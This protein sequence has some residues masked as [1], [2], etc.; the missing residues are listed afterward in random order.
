M[1]MQSLDALRKRALKASEAGDLPQAETLLR[2]AEYGFRRLTCELIMRRGDLLRKT[3]RV[4]EAIQTFAEAA[5]LLPNEATPHL[6]IAETERARRRYDATLAALEQALS[7]AD[8]VFVTAGM[9]G[10]TGTGA[11]PVIAACVS[12]TFP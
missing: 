6:L 9:G 2:E 4:D 5:L 12:V 11:A 7:G 3:D 8:M 1:D 10:G